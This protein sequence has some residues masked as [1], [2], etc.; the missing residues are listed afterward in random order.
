MYKK[1]FRFL[2]NIS[3][4]LSWKCIELL[5]ESI[6]S[7]TTSESKFAP[8]LINYY[9]LTNIKFN[10]NCLINNNNGPSLDAVNLYI[11]YEL[12][13]G[14]DFTL[15]NCLFGFGKLTKNADLDKYKYID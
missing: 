13:L 9:P 3:K 4:D 7:I 11:C 6:E 5:E 8:A 1:Y 2:T 10:G 12:D 15:S 14:I